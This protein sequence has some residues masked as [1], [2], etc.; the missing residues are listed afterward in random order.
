MRS[1]IM[2]RYEAIESRVWKN[3]AGET[4]SIYGA[5]PWGGSDRGTWAIV[6]VGYTVKNNVTGTVGTGR[7]PWDTMVEAEAHVER[8]KALHTPIS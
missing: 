8:L 1:Q 3:D 6:T 7:K 5:C 2:E 4:A